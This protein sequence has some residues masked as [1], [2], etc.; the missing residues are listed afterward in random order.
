MK[1]SKTFTEDEVKIV[2][3]ISKNIEFYRIRRSISQS[4]LAN[5]IGRSP[6]FMNNLVHGRINP[7]VITISRIADALDV[8][9]AN[10]YTD[11]YSEDI[12]IDKKMLH[13]A[14]LI[15]LM[16]RQVQNNIYSMIEYIVKNNLSRNT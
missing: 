1:E 8:P 15:K 3:S 2:K 12:C 11:N 7:T 10:L 13:I 14:N 4:E 16:P 6:T 9:V 5:R